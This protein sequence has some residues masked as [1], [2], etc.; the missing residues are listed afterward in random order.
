MR[1]LLC[2]MWAMAWAAP[3]LAGPEIPGAP[4]TQPIALTGGVIHPVSGPEL[5]DAVLV[6]DQ[7][8]ITAV[9]RDVVLSEGVQR[10]DLAGKHVY[11]GLIDAHSHLGLV[12]IPSVRGTV[13][14]AETGRIN[15]NVKAEVAV[16]PDSELI[17]VTRSGGVL[18]CATAPG[19]GLISGMSAVLQLD[20]WTWEEMC[21]RRN[22]AMHVMWPR[23]VAV[24]TWRLD[25]A[26][27]A[28]TVGR[29]KPLLEL[30]RTFADARAYW[31]A[32]KARN[33]QTAA[34]HDAR[35]EALIPVLEGKVP[36]HVE[37]DEIQ[38]IQSAVAFAQAEGVRVV[39]VGGYDAP[40]CADLLKK[41]DI[42]V[43]VAGVQRLPQ[44]RH[45]PYDA[46]FSV[47]AR[48][49]AAG[50][51]YCIS[52]AGRMGNVRNLPH[53]AALAA[54]FGLP[55]DEAL[56]SITLHAARILGID[57]RLGS[58]EPGKDAT[59]IVTTG[60]PLE[61]TTQVTRAFIQGREV[62]LSDRQKRLYAKYRE[63][64]ARQRG[65]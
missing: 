45:D 59:L 13:D 30:R 23:M 60:D 1:Y 16:N 3:A 63:K 26:N 50:V 29:D 52:G 12:E 41:Y 5:R 17:P 46:A 22:A 20:G 10:I 24:Y 35:W 28:A 4:Q 27:Q 37:A 56:K 21:V 38:Q 32:Q 40:D 51:R 9:G 54:A 2:T 25:D 49:Q 36:L 61:I 44:R 33:P 14:H 19:G 47:P 34:E 39:I 6:F 62:D 31:S 42:P 55:A 8:R 57:D 58:L 18:V 65:T 7:G 43:I 53:H 64:Y 11:P 48:L 15:P